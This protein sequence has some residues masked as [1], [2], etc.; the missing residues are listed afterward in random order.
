MINSNVSESCDKRIRFR[1]KKKAGTRVAVGSL[2]N[3][4]VAAG[5][6]AKEKKKRRHRYCPFTFFGKNEPTSFR[7]CIFKMEYLEAGV[8]NNIFE[9]SIALLKNAIIIS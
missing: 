8:E 5:C 9:K 6:N 1:C 4:S 2:H 7:L 3:L